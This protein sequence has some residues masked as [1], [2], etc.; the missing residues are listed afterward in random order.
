MINTDKKQIDADNLLYADL[1]Y[2]IRGCLFNVYN[3]L[4]HGH[5]EQVYQKAFAEELNQANIPFKR[6]ANL[7]VKYKGKP[8]GNY[9]PDFV[10]DEKVIIETKAVES[11]PKSYEQQL[12]NYLKSTDI[13]LGLLVNFGRPKLEIRRLIWTG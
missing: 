12:T 3:E 11:M 13:K 9:R 5:K 2:K 10:I 6:E 8:V 7:K 4:G 1:T